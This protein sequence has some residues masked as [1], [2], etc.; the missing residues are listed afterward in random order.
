MEY[1]NILFAGAPIRI[2]D[3][4]NKIELEAIRTITGATKGTSHTKLYIEYAKA[5]LHKRRMVS[6]VSMLY[7]IHNKIAPEYLTSILN[8]YKHNENYNLRSKLSYKPPMC[9]LRV[10]SRSFFPFA[11]KLWNDLHENIRKL[12][13]LASFKHELNPKNNN[14]TLYYYGSRWAN[15]HH[16]RMRMNCSSLNNDLCKYLH[17]R[18]NSKCSCGFDTEDAQH[19]ICYCPIFA[20]ERFVMVDALERLGLGTVN[21][22]PNYKLMLFGDRSIKLELQCQIFEVFQTYIEKTQRFLKP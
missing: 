22:I 1:G 12:P 11:I 19:Y 16:S 8:K 20:E 10:F 18:D 13:T 7:N 5:S 9:R 21:G 15:I 2:L 3:K 17:V 14:L 4:L 6:T